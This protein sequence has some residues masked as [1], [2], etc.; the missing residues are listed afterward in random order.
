MGTVF[1]AAAS[2]GVRW[3]VG[4]KK[5][6]Y[7]TRFC[8]PAARLRNRKTPFAAMSLG[9]GRTRTLKDYMGACISLLPRPSNRGEAST[10]RVGGMSVSGGCHGVF[11]SFKR[12]GGKSGAQV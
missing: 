11:K 5:S 1:L 2:V 3:C 6:I 8:G 12:G 7:E 9:R 10:E 4:N